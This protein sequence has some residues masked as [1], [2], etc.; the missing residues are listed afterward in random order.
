MIFTIWRLL[1]RVRGIQQKNHGEGKLEQGP[2]SSETVGQQN[3]ERLGIPDRDESVQSQ[4][5]VAAVADR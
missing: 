1:D 4:F 5:S 3:F 2:G